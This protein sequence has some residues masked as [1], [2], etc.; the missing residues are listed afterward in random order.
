MQCVWGRMGP[1]V[2]SE[3]L[4]TFTVHSDQDIKH[5][6]EE[7]NRHQTEGLPVLRALL[8]HTTETRNHPVDL[9]AMKQCNTDAINGLTRSSLTVKVTAPTIPNQPFNNISSPCTSPNS[10]YS[11]FAWTTSPSRDLFSPDHFLFE[12]HLYEGKCRVL[13]GVVSLPIPKLVHV[14][15]KCN[16][17]QV[18]KRRLRTYLWL[19]RCLG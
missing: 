8:F 4:T 17:S 15:R 18:L 13:L 2:A 19:P 5:M 11:L 12:S 3:N 6:L 1:E 16:V 14:L 10:S 7:H 9:N